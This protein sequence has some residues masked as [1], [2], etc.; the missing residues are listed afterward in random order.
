MDQSYWQKQ[1]KTTPLVKDPDWLIPE[2][3][4]GAL[5]LIGGNSTS[6]ATISRIAE[7]IN[8][9]YPK[10]KSLNLILPNAL[11]S[12]LP[13]LDNITFTKSTDSGS[14]AR[15]AELNDALDSA[16]FNLILGDVTK[17]SETSVALAEAIKNAKKPIL[18]TR[19]TIDSLTED[20]DAWIE[21]DHLFLLASTA[22]LQKLLRALYY[23]KMLIL[24]QPLNQVLD[25]LHKFTLSYP[26]TIITFHS[27]Q[28]ILAYNGEILT[29]PIIDTKYNPLSLWNGELASNLTIFNLWNPNNPLK[30]SSAAILR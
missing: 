14:F 16:D 11:K 22:Q 2:Q 9:H 3:K 6:F 20:A 28:I 25:A 18:L 7:Y 23:P 30:I 19:D 27:D 13:P 12:K 21:H 15:S 29:T 24:S 5:N 17:N 26:A 1:T 4:S 8:N 10:L